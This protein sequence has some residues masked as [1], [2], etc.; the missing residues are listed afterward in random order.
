MT[1][2]LLS[3]SLVWFLVISLITFALPGTVVANQDPDRVQRQCMKTIAG[4]GA[5][6]G[7]CWSSTTTTVPVCGVAT[8]ATLFDAGITF[9]VCGALVAT[10]AISCS[11]T[12]VVLVKII[13]DCFLRR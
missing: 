6:S 13:H 2:R 1:K 5:V 3:R 11:V 8:A 9:S 12:P 7:I 10:A 4:T